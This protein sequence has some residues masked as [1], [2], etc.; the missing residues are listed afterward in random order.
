VNIFRS[1]TF[2]KPG[3]QFFYLLSLYRFSHLSILNS[4]ISFTHSTAIITKRLFI[5]FVFELKS[6]EHF[7]PTTT[8]GALNCN[9]PVTGLDVEVNRKQL[10]DSETPSDNRKGLTV[11]AMVFTP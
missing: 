4:A 2:S 7:P 9:Y 11:E 5:P 10:I 3:L 1:K 8:G 6:L